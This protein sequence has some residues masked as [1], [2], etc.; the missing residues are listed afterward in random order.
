[1]DE[2]TPDPENAEAP[3]PANDQDAIAGEPTLANGDENLVGTQP[4]AAAIDPEVS[5]ADEG[6]MKPPALDVLAGDRVDS[7]PDD[8]LTPD[9]QIAAQDA[10]TRQKRIAAE[11]ARAAIERAAQDPP[12]EDQKEP[13]VALEGRYGEPQTSNGKNVETL[14]D[15]EQRANA[16]ALLD[17][18]LADLKNHRFHMVKSFSADIETVDGVIAEMEKERAEIVAAG[19]QFGT[20]ASPADQR[21]MHE[22]GIDPLMNRVRPVVRE[23]APY[24]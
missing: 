22:S 17:E 3:A 9:Q 11:S 12:S 19:G 6:A 16:L 7:K 18:K 20:D 24:Q 8:Q 21:K 1:M 5:K 15:R 4:D 23:M 10:A 14:V 2:Q 13:V